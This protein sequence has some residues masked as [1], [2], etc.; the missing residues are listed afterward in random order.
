MTP[1]LQLIFTLIVIL[2]AAKLAGYLATLIKQ[3]S[4]F[5]E[6]LVGVILGPSLL[7]LTHLTFITDVHLGEIVYELGE[8]G[9]LLLMFLAGLELNLKDITRNS[10]ASSLAGTLGV[11][12]PIAMGF[13]AGYLTDM[14]PEQS[15][16]LGL[17]LAAT[18]VSI[19]ALTLMELGKLRS[20]V[21]LGLLAAAVFDDILVILILSSILA[22]TSEA[23]GFLGI[24]VVFIR[25]ISFLLL[26]VAA[27]IYLLPWLIRKTADLP[28]SQGTLALSLI[29]LFGY[30][31]AAELIGGMA[32][33]TGSFIAGLMFSRTPE[34]S[35]V[36]PGMRSLAYSFFVPVFFVS[37]GLNMDLHQINPGYLLVM[38]GIVLIAVISKIIGAGLGAKFGGMTWLESLQI[39]IGMISRGEVGLIVAKIG[40]DN[41]LLTSQAFSSI[42]VVVLV[43]TL[44]TPPLLRLSFSNQVGQI[45]IIKKAPEEK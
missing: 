23:S 18:S 25:M 27:G 16:F 12:I 9:V 32:A 17:S 21:G 36:D 24:L 34:R 8:L 44:L 45:S 1:F 14:T 11:I 26:S 40:L 31:F 10:K 30:G 22:F 41:Q 28:I 15:M 3:P 38:A 35:L 42:I 5:G 37:I 20:R 2:F 43:T 4:V 19:S 7:D 33:I 13:L 29:I 6:L 39:G